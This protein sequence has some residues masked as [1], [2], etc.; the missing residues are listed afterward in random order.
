MPWCATPGCRPDQGVRDVHR[1]IRRGTAYGAP[2]DPHAISGQD[3]EVPRGLYF[4]FISA[5]AMAT[6]E[7][8]QQEWINNGNFMNLGEE[9]DPKRRAYSRT[10]RARQR[11]CSGP[12]R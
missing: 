12:S 7:F 1:I 4:I 8:L 5:K 11:H 9:R 6:L 10:G 3:D 2:Y